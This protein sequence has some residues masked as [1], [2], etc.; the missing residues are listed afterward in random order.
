MVIFVLNVKVILIWIV[1]QINVNKL[2]LKFNIVSIIKIMNVFNV[3]KDII[4]CKMD[5]VLKVNKYKIVFNI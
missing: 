4:I 5:N 2:I 3:N 1:I